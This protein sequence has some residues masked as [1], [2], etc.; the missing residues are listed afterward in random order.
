MMTEKS[1]TEVLSGRRESREH[2]CDMRSNGL[3]ARM[4][5]GAAPAGELWYMTSVDGALCE[6]VIITPR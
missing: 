5:W 2:I 4:G 3:G 1:Y 6:R